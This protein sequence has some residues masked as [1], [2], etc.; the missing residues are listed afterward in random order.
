M[1]KP[2]KESDLKPSGSTL[3][4]R[5]SMSMSLALAIVMI[6]AGAFLY[7]W[8][9]S[10]ASDIQERA[11]VEAVSFQGPLQK[12]T[13]EDMRRE[14]EG[15][16]PREGKR[17]ILQPVQGTTKEFPGTNVR[18]VDVMYGENT[19]KP[20]YMYVYGDVKPPLV[21]SKDLKERAGE[22]LLG[23]ILAVTLCVILVGALVAWM[24]AASV[25]APLQ[26]IVSDINQ[27]ASGNLR[28]R[29][30]V[31]AGGE[32]LLLAKSIDRMAGNLEAAQE[33]QLELSVRERE[34]GVASEVREALLPQTTPVVKGY[35]IGALHVDC[36]TPGG[37]FH[38]FLELPDGRV[39]LLVCDVSGRG[40]PGAMIGAIARSYLRSELEKCGDDVAGAFSRANRSIARDARRGMFVTAMYVLLDPKEGIA[41]VACAG[42]KLPI[43]RFTAEDSKIRVVH[44]EGIA[45]GFDK[46]P[47]FDR[48]LQVQKIP[49]EKGDRIVISTTGAVQVRNAAGEEVG[50]KAF[51]RFVLQHAKVPCHT[52]LDQ[53]KQALE[54][55]ADG[56]PFPNDISLVALAR[57]A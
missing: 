5:F 54:G 26:L 22:G 47:V 4:T 46:G 21:V 11:F 44:P 9:V 43:V 40:I 27:I 12:T 15:L 32:I 24:I 10:K 18:R 19:D 41:T 36:P 57:G 7:S 53:V 16:P 31:R 1:A 55:H 28:H 14:A 37:D 29:T 8:I 6:G 25:S 51:Y 38:D 13:F 45:L 17:E 30:R 2:K 33:A 34:I 49:I 39:G 23:M 20:G 35:E 52:M 48:T 42:H 50:E 3:S 56:E